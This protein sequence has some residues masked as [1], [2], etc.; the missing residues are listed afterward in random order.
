LTGDVEDWPI[1]P[2]DIVS[3]WLKPFGVLRRGPSI[4]VAPSEKAGTDDHCHTGMTR[5][6]LQR[7]HH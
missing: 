4:G 2:A 3:F 1:T 5:E 6:H 7:L